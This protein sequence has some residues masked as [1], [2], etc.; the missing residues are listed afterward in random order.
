[1]SVSVRRDTSSSSDESS[2]KA[3]DASVC[4]SRG[5]TAAALRRRAALARCAVIGLCLASASV[6]LATGPAPSGEAL[7]I[8]LQHYERAIAADPEDLKLAADYRQLSI[9]AQ[10]FDRSINFFE[11]LASR[12]GGGPNVQISL[13]FAYIDKVPPAGD[14]R[15]LY[16]GRDAMSALTRSIALR[17]C[18]LAYCMRGV[19]NLYYN[20]FIFHRTDRG[21]A[22]LT[23]ALSMAT[24]DTPPALVALVYTALGDGY[25]KLDNP[26]KAREIWS[27]GASKFPE[28]G[29]LRTRLEKE[30]QALGAEVTAALSAGRRVDTSLTNLLPIR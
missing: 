16:L 5:R 18:V 22:D 17:P 30:G 27:A 14:I 21:V 25:F 24:D 4:R 12:Q 1:L 13:A 10:L 29:R 23:Q 26:A 11:K 6:V 20:R 15:R 8:E 28:D 19:I 9:G 7:Q 3:S 2:L